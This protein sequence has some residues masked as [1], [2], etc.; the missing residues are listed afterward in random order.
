MHFKEIKYLFVLFLLCGCSNS[1]FFS[2]TSDPRKLLKHD[3]DALLSD[4]AFAR[5]TASIKIVSLDRNEILYDRSS[6]LLLLPASTLKLFTTAS[7]LGVLENNYTFK[8]TLSVDTIDAG[9]TAGK[10][11]LKGYGDP[12][13]RTCDLDTLAVQLGGRGITAI[14]DGICVDASFFDDQSWG[15]G[16]MWDDEPD[17]DE[18]CISALSINKNCIEVHVQPAV[19]IG[20]PA[21][22]TLEPMTSYVQILN[23]TSTTADSIRL[24]FKIRRPSYLWPNAV[25]VEGEVLSA[26]TPKTFSLSLRRP[27]LYAGQLLKESLLRHGISI[28]GSVTAGVSPSHA[29]CIAVHSTS[30]DSVLI[31]ELK[32]SDNLSAE[33]ILKTLSAQKYSFPA[34]SKGGIYVV[35]QFMAFIG[36]DTAQYRIVDGSGVSR[37]NLLSS[38]IIVQLLTEMHKNPNLFKRFSAALPIAGVDWY[39]TKQNGRNKRSN[40]FKGKNRNTQRCKLPCGICPD[41]GRGITGIFHYDAE[42][43]IF[44]GCL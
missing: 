18:A 27:E 22:V 40:Q 9:G 13:L 44:A 6:S 38:D 19:R 41:K 35:N 20:D 11:Y 37:Y 1:S 21:F 31:H 24:P 39:I 43:F 36:I 23:S 17:P 30:L 42:F 3:I 8:T 10:I 26:D 33:N 14:R 15:M 25:I 12:D 34:S 16:W 2:F 5:T 4:S 7:A 28:G 32:L 29:A